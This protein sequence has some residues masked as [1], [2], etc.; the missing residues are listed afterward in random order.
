M[1]T[2]ETIMVVIKFWAHIPIFIEYMSFESPFLDSH[3]TSLNHW[4]IDVSYKYK[5]NWVGPT[6]LAIWKCGCLVSIAYLCSLH[7]QVLG[8]TLT[9]LIALNLSSQ[10][11]DHSF[12]H[13]TTHCLTLVNYREFLDLLGIDT[14]FLHKLIMPWRLQIT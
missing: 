5:S 2:T 13:I 10:S 3:L 1:F 4:N 11:I 14:I 6:C 9:P 7:Q 12:N 8:S